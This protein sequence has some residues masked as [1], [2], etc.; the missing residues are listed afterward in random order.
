MKKIS[1]HQILKLISFSLFVW[2]AF[3]ALSNLTPESI[4]I[5]RFEQETIQQEIQK[6]EH[7]NWIELGDR[8]RTRRETG[9][10]SRL[11]LYIYTPEQYFPQTVDHYRG[12]FARNN[13]SFLKKEILKSSVHYY[14]RK[15]DLSASIS[16][17]TSLDQKSLKKEVKSREVLEITI[18]F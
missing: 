18:Y 3:Q 14:Y 15:G 16:F 9:R 17:W 5:S 11:A 8:K 13:W 12:E 2:I 10:R 7:P 4:R 1:G 6:I